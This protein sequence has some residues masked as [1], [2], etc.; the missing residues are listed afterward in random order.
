MRKDRQNKTEKGK[1]SKASEKKKSPA[2]EDRELKAGI[3]K[4]QMEQMKEVLKETKDANFQLIDDGDQ[5]PIT[6]RHSSSPKV[7]VPKIT[8]P[9]A[10]DNADE[11]CCQVI[12]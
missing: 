8:S 10:T 5:V 2:Q 1:G 11:T 7:T 9:K 4:A 3:Q 12:I 6:P